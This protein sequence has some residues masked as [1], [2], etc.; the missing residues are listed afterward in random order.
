MDLVSYL[1]WLYRQ[2]LVKIHHGQ[3][4]FLGLTKAFVVRHLR[5]WI[6]QL[7]AVLLN[8]YGLKLSILDPHF[9]SRN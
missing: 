3:L 2:D 5:I 1:E 4:P 7:S 9:S 6:Q 8:R